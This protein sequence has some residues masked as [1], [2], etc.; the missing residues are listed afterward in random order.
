MPGAHGVQHEPSA[1]SSTNPSQPLFSGMI[2]NQLHQ[3]QAQFLQYRQRQPL[4]RAPHELA[5]TRRPLYQ[6]SRAPYRPP[7]NRPPFAGYQPG[8]PRPLSSFSHFNRFSL[9]DSQSAT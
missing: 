1:S 2:I 8:E 5:P 3:Q 9:L 7:Y 4:L 6:P